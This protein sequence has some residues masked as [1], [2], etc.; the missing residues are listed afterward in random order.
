MYSYRAANGHKRLIE[1]EHRIAKFRR[2]LWPNEDRE[3]SL[4]QFWAVK[5]GLRT[6]AVSN[7]VEI[8]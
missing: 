3:E 1:D 4:V 8:A 6:V 5:G 7:I 2:M